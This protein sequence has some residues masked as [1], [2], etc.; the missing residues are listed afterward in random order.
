[1][2]RIFLCAAVIFSSAVVLPTIALAS[3]EVNVSRGLVES[4]KP[5]AV[6]GYDVVSYFTDGKPTHG[7]SKFDEVYQGATYRFSSE[8]NLKAFKDNP[9][10]YAPQFGGFCAYGT[11]LGKKFDGDP[12]DWTIAEGK[13]YLN[14]NPDIQEKFRKDVPGFIGKADK[15]WTKIQHTGVSEL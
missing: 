3:D 6:H 5:L 9:A 11:A 4:G 8:E 1:M 12:E 10:K 2:K 7:S 13:L 15:N 14:L